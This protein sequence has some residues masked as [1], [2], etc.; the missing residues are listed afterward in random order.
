MCSTRA[1]DQVDVVPVPPPTPTYTVTTTIPVGA[2]GNPAAMGVA[3]NAS[4]LLVANY[5]AGTVTVINTATNSVAAT[6]TLPTP[7]GGHTASTPRG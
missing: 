5:A 6:V 3:P 2:L 1:N 7:A 4:E